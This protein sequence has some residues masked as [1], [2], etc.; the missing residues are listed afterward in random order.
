[1]IAQDAKQK[2]H[3]VL[4]PLVLL[5]LIPIISAP[6]FLICENVHSAS[7]SAEL[8]GCSFIPTNFPLPDNFQSGANKTRARQFTAMWVPQKHRPLVS[9]EE[10]ADPYCRA[11]LKSLIFSWRVI[12]L[13]LNSGQ[14]WLL[15]FGGTAIARS[16]G[17]AIL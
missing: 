3:S 4:L 15:R 9:F 14:P 13:L 10:L 17:Q 12:F 7:L 11:A 8:A 2:I 6:L 1:V 16:E 5:V